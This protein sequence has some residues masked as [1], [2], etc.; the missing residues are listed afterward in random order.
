MSGPPH[1]KLSGTG[2]KRKRTLREEEEQKTAHSLNKFFNVD[3][4]QKATQSNDEPDCEVEEN[5]VQMDSDEGPSTTMTVD[6]STSTTVCEQSV[7]EKS[8]TDIEE[9]NSPKSPE[10]QEKDHCITTGFLRSSRL[11]RC[12]LYLILGYHRNEGACKAK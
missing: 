10:L 12:H 1:K 4:K 11:A 6:A 3:Q 8:D 9:V 5:P 7:E 2:F